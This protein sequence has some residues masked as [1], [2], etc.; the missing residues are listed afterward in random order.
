MNKTTFYIDETQNP[1]RC[2]EQQRN[3]RLRR[4]REARDRLTAEFVDLLMTAP[5]A[6]VRWTGTVTDLMEVAHIAYLQGT[7]CAADGASCTFRQLVE[8]ACSVLNVK[9][10]CNPQTCAR[11][12]SM[13]KG[14]RNSP[15][16]DRYVRRMERAGMASLPVDMS[17]DRA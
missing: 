12:A 3:D 4:F 10:P 5:G 11:R 16:I 6:G 15:F 2:S 17:A 9:V 14:V 7:V 8:R 13:R 1:M